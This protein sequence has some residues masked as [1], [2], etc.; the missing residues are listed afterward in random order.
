MTS[1]VNLVDWITWTKL[2][3]NLEFET[4]CWKP[5]LESFFFDFFFV[6]IVKGLTL[7]CEEVNHNWS[8]KWE[9]KKNVKL[10]TCSSLLIS[11][12]LYW[13]FVDLFLKHEIHPSGT[14]NWLYFITGGWKNMFTMQLWF[15][16][17]PLFWIQYHF[18]P[19]FRL[20][21]FIYPKSFFQLSPLFLT[22]KLSITHNTNTHTHCNNSRNESLTIH[23]ISWCTHSN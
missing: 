3:K 9:T 21:M 5:H 16:T 1:K 12:I 23:F 6:F 11:F 15:Y 19:E 20:F 13:I 4:M 2:S 10:K 18:V 14:M 8:V 22:K 17:Q 7:K